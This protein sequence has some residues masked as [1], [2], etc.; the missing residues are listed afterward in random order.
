MGPGLYPLFRK[1]LSLNATFSPKGIQLSPSSSRSSV[2]SFYT[3]EKKL[4]VKVELYHL[5]DLKKG[6][7]V[8]R[9]RGKEG[10]SNSYSFWIS[11]KIIR[12]V[13]NF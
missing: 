2:F 11:T 12:N 10:H 13:H 4:N 6:D 3:F 5:N 7:Y 1:G 8:S 9:L